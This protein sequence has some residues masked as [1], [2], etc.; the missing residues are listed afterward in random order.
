MDR[1]DRCGCIG[2]HIDGLDCIAA[3]RG[4]IATLEAELA[5]RDVTIRG[6]RTKLMQ[7]D[8]AIDGLLRDH[9]EHHRE[10]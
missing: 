8:D 9:A 2:Q 7:A 3:L 1:C 4:R 5:Q 6:L 10:G